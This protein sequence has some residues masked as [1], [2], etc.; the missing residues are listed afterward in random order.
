M[1][2]SA[3]GQRSSHVG[4]TVCLLHLYVKEQHKA[5]N[6][7]FVM[8]HRAKMKFIKERSS[9]S[10]K[11]IFVET[12]GLLFV[13]DCYASILNLDN[14]V[15]LKRNADAWDITVHDPSIFSADMP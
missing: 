4:D 6:H 11:S 5:R 3:G 2:P 14:N 15:L 7:F 9:L 12:P 10:L 13:L 1:I 8:L